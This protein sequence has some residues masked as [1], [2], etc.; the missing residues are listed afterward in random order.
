ML[1][2][3]EYQGW[4]VETVEID[5][6]AGL[7]AWIEIRYGD[8]RRHVATLA[9]RDAVLREHGVDPGVL[10]VLDTIEDGCE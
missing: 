6:G 3:L 2:V 5:L 4:Q 7:R 9:E 8:Q 1:P 10:T